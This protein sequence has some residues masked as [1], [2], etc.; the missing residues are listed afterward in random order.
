M[1]SYTTAS[2]NLQISGGG[3]VQFVPWKSS[4]GAWTSSRIESKASWT[5]AAGKVMQVEVSLRLGGEASA[6]AAGMWPAVW[7]LGDSIHHG[8][9]WPQC[10]ELDIFEMVNGV[11]TAFGTA[12]CIAASC[13]QPTGLQGSVATDSDWHSYALKV[14]RTSNNWATESIS[15][16]RDGVV[17]YTITGATINDEGVW[18][19]LA[20]S[21]LY[22][23]MNV[24]VGGSCTWSCPSFSV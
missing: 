19:T 4:S 2:S 3:T 13:N 10:G 17:F 6:N 22:L 7:M 16:M 5:P 21:P 18:A 1:Q 24:A 23:I 20:H 11:D 15:W 8:T 12:H 9:P 14:N